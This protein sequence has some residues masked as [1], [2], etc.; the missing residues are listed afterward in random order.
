MTQQ[1]RPS[2]AARLLQGT[3]RLIFATL[4]RPR[5]T[6]LEN[7]RTPGPVIFAA[8]HQ[9]LLDGPLL[10][11]ILGPTAAFAMTSQWADRPFMRRVARL[12]PILAIDPTKPM[13]VKTLARRI[14]AGQS[15]VIFP[16][17]R[18][19]ATGAL[20]KVYPGTAWLVDQADV[21]V[22]PIHFEGLEFSRQSRLKRGYPRRWFPRLRVHVGAP[23]RLVLDGSLKGKLRRERAAQMVGDILETQRFVALN[24][25]D[26]LPQA[27]ADTLATYGA[28]RLALTD[29][30]GASLT[31]GRLHLAADV[32]ARRLQPLLAGQKT[33]GVLLPT[34]AGVPAVLLALWRLGVTP[35][36]LNPTL[37]P[38][39]MK[40]CL[41]TAGATTVLTSTAMIDQ[42][43]LHPVIADLEAAGTRVLRTE[44][45]RAG[46][47]REM[48]LRALLSSR[49][50]PARHGT[51]FG[52]PLTRDTP[53]VI[54]FTSGTEGA[55]KGV[56]LSHG[57]ILAN[58]A[59]LRARTDINAG[60]S[61]FTA[62]P[63]FHSFGLT[64]GILLPLVVGAPV[65]AYPS[66]LHYRII[67][68]TAYYH[69]PTIIFGT[70]SFLSGWGRRAHD[71]DFAS[72]RAAI[73]GAEP[74]RDSTR[75]LWSRR[76]GVRI[77]EGYGATE[78]APVLALNTPISS[79]NGSV[80]R[81]LPA[82][83]AHLDPIPGVEAFRLSVRGPNI[84]QGYIRATAPGV[85]EPP[86]GGWYDTG[87]AV[88]LDAEGFLTIKGRIKRFAKIGGEMVSLAAVEA[89][90]ERT[91][92]DLS[93]AAIALP[94]PRKGNRILLALATGNSG[95]TP[96]M[97]QL[98][99]QA[100]TEGLAEIMLPARLEVM[101]KLPMLA[102]GKPD[103]PALTRA[104]ADPA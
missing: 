10:F 68:E 85:I 23:Q 42:I 29:P 20:M 94:D 54:L 56:V 35:A 89:L 12:V 98:K 81:L 1:P 95:K 62:L 65:V 45:I 60:D 76:F 58:I 30:T 74:I 15:C 5:I 61:I 22:I 70:D 46:V 27:L 14:T 63:V 87:D 71:Y 40:T 48:K 37:G 38:G 52:A 24:R 53:A 33:V 18:I 36:M 91:W 34:A 102:S 88:T 97:A 99:A 55:P 3:L 7:L 73:A 84:M 79:R 17:G 26:T 39:P 11:S 49:F 13:T 47:T 82:I 59:Q 50:G 64:A 67:P 19:T 44:D 96:E 28:S 86:E 2:L 72:L 6:G 66:P 16:E 90:A 21:P 103:Y 43:K 80:G 78:T 41:A 104:F 51:P 32:L 31:L 9:S 93:A 57:N 25:Y 75:E 101:H 92:P 8:N 69:M 77:L 100:R 83:E 4:L